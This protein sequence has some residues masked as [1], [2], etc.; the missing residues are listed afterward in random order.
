MSFETIV[1][2]KIINKNGALAGLTIKLNVV[3]ETNSI[4]GYRNTSNIFTGTTD[5]GGTVQF[6]GVTAGTY[7]V[8]VVSGS[9]NFYMYNY[10]VKNSYTVVEGGSEVIEE[11]RTFVRSSETLAPSG[12]LVPNE[13]KPYTKLGV[14]LETPV[15]TSAL[16]A[17]ISG[18]FY[19]RLDES[20]FTVTSSM[21]RE[22]GD[23]YLRGNQNVKLFQNFTFKLP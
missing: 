13:Y 8:Q 14:P 1:N 23:S 10:I 22:T 12:I 17:T 5:A 2:G 4:T 15:E 11:S 20:P 18:T 16:L 7:D 21:R 9:S 19:N 3:K 6:S